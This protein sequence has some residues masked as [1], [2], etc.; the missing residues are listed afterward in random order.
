MQHDD[1]IDVCVFIAKLAL[2]N[3]MTTEIR[4]KYIELVFNEIGLDFDEAHNLFL[5]RMGDAD[6]DENS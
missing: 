6:S 3:D 5:K 4:R 2:N 1:L